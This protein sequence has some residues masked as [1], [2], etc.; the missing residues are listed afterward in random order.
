MI[1]EL[2]NLLNV[3]GILVELAPKQHDVLDLICRA[4]RIPVQELIISGAIP[5]PSGWDSR[6]CQRAL[7]TLSHSKS[8]LTTIVHHLGGDMPAYMAA[9]PLLGLRRRL[10][11][12]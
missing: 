3:L 2:L 8:N 6:L 12:E 11:S 5:A 9:A 10:R 4:P 7:R 1:T